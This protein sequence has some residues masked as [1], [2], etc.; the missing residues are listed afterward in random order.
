LIKPFMTE[1]SG[2]KEHRQ[3]LSVP[4]GA[5]H[6]QALQLQRLHRGNIQTDGEG[7]LRGMHAKGE[8][9]RHRWWQGNIITNGV[10]LLPTIQ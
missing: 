1:L 4:L 10:S 3:F 9:R 8:L 5:I 7:H 6:A 2:R